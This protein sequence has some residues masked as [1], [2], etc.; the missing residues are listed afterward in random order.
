[1]SKPKY[2][3][4]GVIITWDELMAT[5]NNDGVVYMRGKVQN[6]AFIMGM[7]VGTIKYCLIDGGFMGG[8]KK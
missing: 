1:M 7:M 2:H 8:R 3:K 6:R 4:V 5:L